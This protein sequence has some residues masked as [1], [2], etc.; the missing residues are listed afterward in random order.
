MRYAQ[1]L[2]DLQNHSTPSPALALAPLIRAHFRP[3]HCRQGFRIKEK[4]QRKW[5]IS[6]K[7]RDKFLWTRR[8]VSDLETVA[9]PWRAKRAG[10]PESR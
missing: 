2:N 4:L 10:R 6:L 3:Y 8:V 9:Q 5:G 7:W 1:T